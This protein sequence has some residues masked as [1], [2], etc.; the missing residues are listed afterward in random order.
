MPLDVGDSESVASF[1]TALA[2]RAVDILINNAGVLGPD[3]QSALETDFEGFLQTL[4]VNTLGPLR[5]TA[6]AAA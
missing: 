4:N 2:G 3:R 5:V 1:A 6:G